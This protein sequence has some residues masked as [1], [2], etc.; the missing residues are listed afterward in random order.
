[1]LQ[2]STLRLAARDKKEQ[3]LT[4]EVTSG[5]GSLTYVER[6]PVSTYSTY[7]LSAGFCACG[8]SSD[9]CKQSNLLLLF[10]L[11]SSPLVAVES[12]GQLLFA[13]G[14]ARVYRPLMFTVR[15]ENS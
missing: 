8:A 11:L 14:R 10:L 6:Q 9:W 5:V 2:S 1:M 12:L 15:E 13:R 7:A 4:S 3:K